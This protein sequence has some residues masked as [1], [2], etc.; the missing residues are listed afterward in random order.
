MRLIIDGDGKHTEPIDGQL[1]AVPLK[2]RKRWDFVAHEQVGQEAAIDFSDDPGLTLQEPAEDADI[3]VL[4]KRM[5]VT[6]GSQLPY[7][8]NPR[9]LYG[10]FSEMP[11]DPVEMA[12][13]MRQGELAFMRIPAEVRQRYRNP[14]ELFEWMENDDNYEEAVKLGLLEKKEAPAK[15]EIA[16]LNDT[17]KAFGSKVSSSTSSD[18]EPLVPTSNSKENK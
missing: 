17:L 18:K 13:L 11:D 7:F 1:P 10:D 4:M 6:D 5:G 3:N 9:A 8:P 12:E 16:E 2:F 15:S 14:Q